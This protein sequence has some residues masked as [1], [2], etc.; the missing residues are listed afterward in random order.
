LNA[1]NCW[2]CATTNAVSIAASHS[3]AGERD[4]DARE[5]LLGV[6]PRYLELIVAQ[7]EI[8]LS[9]DFTFWRSLPKNSISEIRPHVIWDIAPKLVC[10]VTSLLRGE[11]L[12]EGP[13][14]LGFPEKQLKCILG[15]IARIMKE[16]F[17]VPL[18]SDL[19]AL[20]PRIIVP[21]LLCRL[22]QEPKVV[23]ALIA[24]RVCWALAFARDWLHL[25]TSR[26]A[27]STC[28]TLAPRPLIATL[29]GTVLF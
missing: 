18:D 28:A 11:V 23:L 13:S 6:P 29:T 20:L 10:H 8:Q 9:T 5:R 7:P 4:F 24:P 2:D 1:P 3:L 15:W 14:D 17:K 21:V 25:H 16:V 26:T 27:C 22:E 12:D 19:S